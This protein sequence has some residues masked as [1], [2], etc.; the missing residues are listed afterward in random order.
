MLKIGRFQIRQQLRVISALQLVIGIATLLCGLGL[1]LL[2]TAGYFNNPNL[3]SKIA[4]H[5]AFNLMTVLAV[6]LI[7]LRAFSNYHFSPIAKFHPCSKS[8][9]TDIPLTTDQVREMARDHLDS[10]H[11]L[12]VLL[13]TNLFAFFSQICLSVIAATI[14]KY[15]ENVDLAFD[16]IGYLFIELIAILMCYPSPRRRREYESFVNGR[17]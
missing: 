17:K 16:T 14:L 13:G 6:S 12:R 2:Y 11:I 5:T 4:Y 8:E 3:A 9:T 15:D 10:I 1:F 7:A